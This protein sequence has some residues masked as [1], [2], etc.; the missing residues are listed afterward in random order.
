[1]SVQQSPNFTPERIGYASPEE[2]LAAATDPH[3]PT[4]IL[5][6]LALLPGDHN[7][8][9]RG[10][11][12]AH[13]AIRPDTLAVLADDPET[14]VRRTVAGNLNTPTDVVNRLA[15]DHE[16]AV[17]AFALTNPNVEI[18]VLRVC[19]SDPAC[20]VA[21]AKNPE[22]PADVLVELAKSD[23]A[24]VRLLVA[25]HDNLNS[26]AFDLLVKDSDVK[27]VNALRVPS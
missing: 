9:V 24:K 18:G 27:V 22:T 3:T 4:D 10:A 2:R 1:M 14:S 26:E 25:R 8:R 7:A 16:Q 15:F 17:R 11:V 23:R 21:L 20:A 13:P 6:A 5:H 19:V 12:V